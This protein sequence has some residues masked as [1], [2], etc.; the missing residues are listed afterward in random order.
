MSIRDR[1]FIC[2]ATAALAAVTLT[3]ADDWPQWRGPLR[4]GVSRET[5][6][7]KELPAGGPHLTWRAT[8]I[9]AGYSSVS[10]AKGK[11]FTIGDKEDASFAIALDAGTGKQIWAT[12][13]GKSGAPGWGGFAGPRSTPTVD[14][15]LVFVVGQWGELVCLKADSGKEIWRKDFTSDFAAPRPEWGFAESPLV[16]GAAVV[17]TPGGPDGTVVAL[18]KQ[19]GSLIW[20]TKDFTDRAHY[21]SLIL[22]EIGGVKQYIQLTADNVV[23]I[24][25]KDGKLLWKAARKGAT[26]VIPTPIVHDNLVYVTSGYG[27]GCNLFKINR[28]GNAFAAEEVYSNKLMQN[29][30]GGVV[31]IG[32]YI[33]GHSDSKGW[34]CQEMATGKALWQEKSKMGKGSIVAADGKLWLRGEDGKGTVALIDA[35]TQGYKDHGTFNPPDRSDKNSWA[36]PV[37]ANGKL[38]LRDQDVLLCYDV[39]A[40]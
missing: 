20:R 28:E 4:D 19:T 37:I 21:S 9:G 22:A 12:K 40:P 13:V 33:Y 3:R 15:D 1:F 6:L 8:G 2:V 7:L 16:D 29:H 24:A 10:V 34:T 38:Y 32:D 17:I 30:H 31:R 14:N 36:H 25:A 18:N 11:I 26:A 27:I 39:K 35:S 23:G 5:G